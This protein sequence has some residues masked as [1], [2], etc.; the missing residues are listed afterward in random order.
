MRL[1]FLMGKTPHSARTIARTN[2]D[3]ERDRQAYIKTCP[4][5]YK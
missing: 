5:F 3:S 4:V 1:S 2:L